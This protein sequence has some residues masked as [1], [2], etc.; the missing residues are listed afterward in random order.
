MKDA[1]ALERIADALEHIADSLSTHERWLS[2]AAEGALIA[3][4]RQADITSALCRVEVLL[5]Q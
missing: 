5:Q 2:M 1:E 4:E 3:S